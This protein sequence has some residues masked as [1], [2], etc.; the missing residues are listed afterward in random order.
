MTITQLEKQIGN[1][2]NFNFVAMY[3]WKLK[4]TPVWFTKHEPFRV[5]L[6]SGKIAGER[7]KSCRA[8]STRLRIFTDKVLR[9]SPEWVH[10]CAPAADEQPETVRAIAA[11]TS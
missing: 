6:R 5:E 2:R 11:S 3:L 7:A 1:I 9:H 10:A 4:A 8:R